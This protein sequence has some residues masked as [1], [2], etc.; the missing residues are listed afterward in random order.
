VKTGKKFVIKAK[1]LPSNAT[2]TRALLT[3]IGNETGGFKTISIT[4]DPT[5]L[6]AVDIATGLV[7]PQA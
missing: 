2:V 5:T 3:I 7:S 6:Q 4:V 1:A